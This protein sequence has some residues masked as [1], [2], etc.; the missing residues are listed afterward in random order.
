MK[1]F[2]VLP[3]LFFLAACNSKAPAP[4]HTTLPSPAAPVTIAPNLSVLEI[5][6]GVF[7]V[8]HEFPIAQA[9][10]M[11][12]DIS[13]KDLLIIDAP[14][15]SASTRDLLKWAK[16]TFGDR[17]ITAINTHSHMDRVAGNDVFLAEGADVYSSDLTIKYVKK[18]KPTELKSL[19]SRVS[20]PAIKAEFAKMKIREANHSFPL[21][22][23]KTLSFG[24]KKAEI[25]YPG[26]G[27]TKDN[28]VVYL[29]D[30]K[31]L[32]GGCFIVGLPKLGYIKEADLKEWPKA[33]DKMSRFDAKWVI[34]GH[35]TSYSPDLIEHTKKLV[36]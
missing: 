28:V 2:L 32:Y 35:G 18:S 22:E 20:D 5:E 17:K 11:V 27:H 10:S 9:N 15:T 34:P 31:I 24:E 6:K 36:K 25:F 21:K 13:P 3:I 16:D 1:R 7:V 4:A 19:A 14:W 12:V 8:S 29:P 33:L 30:Y 26:H 23:G